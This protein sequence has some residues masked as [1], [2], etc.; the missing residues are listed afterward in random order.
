MDP[1]FDKSD[2]QNK[3]LTVVLGVAEDSLPSI[4]IIS[5]MIE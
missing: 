5:L 1:L 2:G 4:T 3:A